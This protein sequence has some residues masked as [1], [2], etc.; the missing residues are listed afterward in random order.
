MA[1]GPTAF[2]GP[3]H[4]DEASLS[5]RRIEAYFAS[6]AEA[7]A[8]QDALIA[9]GIPADRVNITEADAVAS[10]LAPADN[11]VIG[12]IREAVLPDDSKQATRKAVR[13]GGVILTVWPGQDHTDRAVDII[14]AGKPSHFD[15][16]LERWRNSPPTT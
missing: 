9:A 12:R 4:T 1:T 14:Q 16:G 13:E 8:T 11:T 7:K 2:N 5:D 3:L 15:A 10:N 6:A